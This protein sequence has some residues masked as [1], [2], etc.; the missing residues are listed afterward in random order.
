MFEATVVRRADVL[1]WDD[2]DAVVQCP[3][4]SSWHRHFVTKAFED[5]EDDLPHSE[6]LKRLIEYDQQ[7]QRVAT[8]RSGFDMSYVLKFPLSNYEIERPWEPSDPSFNDPSFKWKPC[9][10]RFVTDGYLSRDLRWKKEWRNDAPF[11]FDEEVPT[12]MGAL[13]ELEVGEREYSMAK[14][15]AGKYIHLLF[16][17]EGA[18]KYRDSLDGDV[19]WRSR[20]QSCEEDLRVA[21]QEYD[22]ALA[23]LL[24]NT[25]GM[26]EV[27]KARKNAQVSLKAV[28]REIRHGCREFRFLCIYYKGRAEGEQSANQTKDRAAEDV[29]DSFARLS[30][31]HESRAS[32][33]KIDD[34]PSSP[35]LDE[36]T[37]EGIERR[38][39]A[40]V[41]PG[42]KSTVG[43]L[44]CGEICKGFFN[45]KEFVSGMENQPLTDPM[46]GARSLVGKAFDIAEDVG[47]EFS[48]TTGIDD[49]NI[50]VRHWVW[51]VGQFDACHVEAKA[52]AH[53]ISRDVFLLK[54]RSG[55]HPLC[56][57]WKARPP[58]CVAATVIYVHHN[59]I[60]DSCCRF[61]EAVNTTLGTRFVAV[62]CK[63][64][65][66]FRSRSNSIK[67]IKMTLGDLPKGMTVRAYLAAQG[68]S[69]PLPSRTFLSSAAPSSR[70]EET[71]PTQ[72]NIMNQ[73]AG[74]LN[75]LKPFMA[76]K[77]SVSRTY[78][79]EPQFADA[80]PP[81]SQPQTPPRR[82]SSAQES[83]VSPRHRSYTFTGSPRSP[84]MLVVC[85]NCGAD[86]Y[87]TSCQSPKTS[88]E[89]QQKHREEARRQQVE[90]K[91][92]M[93]QPQARS[94]HKREK[95]TRDA[96]SVSPELRPRRLFGS[97]RRHE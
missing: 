95:D 45:Y 48:D 24:T 50:N 87:S 16:K 19:R 7:S 71:E 92:R 30:L 11:H 18:W 13:Q 40:I 75:K 89:Q 83:S 6:P 12:W 88:R 54:E 15:A 5:D 20:I 3:Y 72:A 51:R 61:I 65:K 14:S 1:W 59:E 58:D 64:E 55:G 90:W 77:T 39:Q 38:L 82:L 66:I 96:T 37:K 94:D 60:C 34:H 26:E 35:I 2:W 27:N 21:K 31:A 44:K 36:A 80:H 49:E 85:F 41:K 91:R 23:A 70:P 9:K 69:T 79:Q 73:L 28:V 17:I 81:P 52:I 63:D 62:P 57:L 46:T 33:G 29:L 32:Q 86:H 67:T 47:F 74:G 78:N 76:T 97:G 8:C 25:G 43:L 56:R 22:G 93:S 84:R 53:A 4:C 10:L 42:S 68:A